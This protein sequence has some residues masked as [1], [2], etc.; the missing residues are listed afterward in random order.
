MQ[1]P[2]RV[3]EK[4]APIAFD[5]AGLQKLQQMK[6][7]APNSA[8][9][10]DAQFALAMH[11]NHYS[12]MPL[13]DYLNKVGL[14]RR[15]LIDETMGSPYYDYAIGALEAPGVGETPEQAAARYGGKLTKSEPSFIENIARAFGQGG[16]FGWGDEVVAGGA[17]AL[18]PLVHGDRGK[19][20]RQRYDAYLARERGD[21]DDFRKENPVAAYGAE[22]AGAIPTSVAAGGT[23]AGQG[24]NTL[25]R[26]G[27]NLAVN[28]GQGGIYGAGA[29]EGD[30]GDRAVGAATGAAMGAGTGLVLDGV[31]G[32]VNA[33]FKQGAKARAVTE[34]IDTA[35]AADALKANSQAAYKAAETAGV[36]LKPTATAILKHDLGSFLTDEG[37][38]VGGKM[39][40]DFGRVRKAMVHLDK[41]AGEPMTIKA[42]QRLEESFQNAAR[43]TKPGEARVGGIM[44][45]Q[46]DD[47]MD[48][49]PQ[50]AFEGSGN[51]VEAASKWK[52][53]KDQW[54]VHKRTKALEDAIYSA[55]LS[56]NFT[57]G[58]K[59]EFR[60]MLLNDKQR[61]RL[62]PED[63]AEMEKFV[64]G[65]PIG[66]VMKYLANGGGMGQTIFA[67][68]AGGPVGAGAAL[69][70]PPAIR[71]G[72][73]RSARR[74]ADTVRASTALGQRPA[75]APV[76][77]VNL[78]PLAPG[79]ANA[80][81]DPRKYLEILVTGGR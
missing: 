31:A 40:G 78:Q 11:Q 3:P 55:R 61:G 24:A 5:P 12:D 47:Y 36:T 23:L 14:D 72:L 62:L 13:V 63:I 75:A 17:A 46:L 30:L 1:E 29:A 27:A 37:L 67:G 52:V 10:T 33:A 73:D 56:G 68:M 42:F 4:P 45:K 79:A 57:E 60:R 64:E 80:N 8:G 53:G 35:P 16:M 76:N 81:D 9:M 43:S 19:D 74:T 7:E 48:S 26:V 39:V 34:A 38:M 54:A 65:G 50:G 32:A 15:D 71:A 18:D 21:I 28:A 25:Q 22:I 66:N 69:L 49:L 2:P 70:G 51:G 41:L 44:L 20:F 58:L 77:G 59:G 6:A